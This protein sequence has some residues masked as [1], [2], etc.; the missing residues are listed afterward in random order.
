MAIHLERPKTATRDRIVTRAAT[1][2]AEWGF[3]GASVSAIAAAVGVSKPA[4]Y[5]HFADKDEIYA[6]IVATVL[7]GMVQNANAALAEIEDPI[8]KLRA[9]MRAHAN[10]FEKNR[11]AYI[12]AQLGFR[13]LRSPDKTTRATEYRDSYERL[14]RSILEEGRRS[15][16][17][18]IADVPTAGRLVLSA[19]N[20]TARWY[21]PN[22]SQS[23]AEIAD[24][25]A[26]MLI[27]GFLPRHPGRKVKQRPR[28]K[29]S[30]SRRRGKA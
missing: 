30:I 6:E 2:F 27:D 23:A 1:L 5:H 28:A 22:G 24:R 20:W 7:S 13:G 26:A 25:Y 9:F 19:L 14:L 17:L 8:E 15:S 29:G 21:R 18:S 16:A 12:A 10:Y 3:E 11:D 4:L